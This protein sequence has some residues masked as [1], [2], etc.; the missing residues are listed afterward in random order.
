M[1][2]QGASDQK[3]IETCNKEE[4]HIITRNK[5]DFKLPREKIKIGIIL[6]SLKKEYNWLSKFK[7]LFNTYDKH[8][9]FYHKIITIK[10]EEKALEYNKLVGIFNEFWKSN[11]VHPVKALIQL[12]DGNNS[13]G[14]L[15][16]CELVRY[17]EFLFIT[18]L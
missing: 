15:R 16:N 3:I 2:Y 12:P 18:R 17:L 5:K 11:E 14:G 1:K 6:V 7:K 9:D 8:K 13:L 4:F 10:M